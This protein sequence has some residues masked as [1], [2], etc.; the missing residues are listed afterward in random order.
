MLTADT[1]A[2]Q[3][4]IGSSGN[5][6]TLSSSGVSLAG[7]AR[8]TK[9]LLITPEY[10]NSVLDA[11]SGSNNTGTMT[12]G[13]DMTNRMNYYKW[14]TSQVTNQSYDVVAQI[15]IPS[16]FSAWSGSIS[17][18]S[19]T[20][21]TTN[22]TITLAAIDSAGTTQCNFVSA[23]PGSTSTWTATSNC[24]LS[25]GTYTAGDYITLRIRLQ[26]PTSGDTRVGNISLSYLTSY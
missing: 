3:V 19:Y 14:T 12:S 6:I 5:T 22:G 1:S 16:D 17:V 4:V 11:G 7:T 25:A 2:G 13:Y 21:N 15:P 8:K 24:T 18:K 26:A 20:S 9:T 23:T 10:P